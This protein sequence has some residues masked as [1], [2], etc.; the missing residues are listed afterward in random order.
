MTH[1]V[2]TYEARDPVAV[3]AFGPQAVTLQ[4]QHIPYLIEQFLFRLAC[5]RLWRYNHIHDS[6]FIGLFPSKQAD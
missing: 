3:G 2:K 6:A 1:P 4:S 5:N